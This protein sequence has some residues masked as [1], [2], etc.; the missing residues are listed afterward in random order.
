MNFIVGRRSIKH[1]Y[2]YSTIPYTVSVYTGL[3]GKKTDQCY[4]G[5]HMTYI[6]GGLKLINLTDFAGFQLSQG[7]V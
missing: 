5:N 6:R 3:L 4:G 7:R 2:L 1:Y